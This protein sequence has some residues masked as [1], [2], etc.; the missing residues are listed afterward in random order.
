MSGSKVLSKATLCALGLLHHPGKDKPYITLN[1]SPLL[2][3][4]KNAMMFEF[5]EMSEAVVDY[6]SGQI[7]SACSLIQGG[8]LLS[9]NDLLKQENCR[10]CVNQGGPLP[11]TMKYPL[12]TSSVGWD[13][14]EKVGIRGPK[15]SHIS[16][17]RVRFER[18]MQVSTNPAPMEIENQGCN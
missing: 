3:G 1:W 10:S 7:N 4:A 5:D 12:L 17:P 15:C 2:R 8:A 18:S 6:L 14:P 9:W 11:S 16:V 13:R